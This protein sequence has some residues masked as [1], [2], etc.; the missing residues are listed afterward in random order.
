MPFDAPSFR[1]AM[2]VLATILACLV[3]SPADAQRRIEGQRQG[4]RLYQ[5]PAGQA[6]GNGAVVRP[7]G[8][9]GNDALGQGNV[10]DGSLEV[11]SGGRNYGSRRMNAYSYQNLQARN[12]VVTNNVAGG[13]GFR[14]DVGYRAPGDFSGETGGDSIYRFDRGSALSSLNFLSSDRSLDPFNIAQG[15]GVFQ[16]RRDFTTLPEV[17][18]VAGVR[19]IDDAQI[20][21]D[22]AN[23]VISSSNLIETAVAPS[24]VG[25]V[26][27]AE[28]ERLQASGSTVR[29]IQYRPLNTPG[30]FDLYDEAS[31]NGLAIESDDETPSSGPVRF[32]AA[33]ATRLAE[34]ARIDGSLDRSEAYDRILQR[35]FESYEDRDDV[36]V[37]ATGL[38]RM[39]QDF[40]RIDGLQAPVR[41]GDPDEERPGNSSERRE[42]LPGERIEQSPL[43]DLVDDTMDFEVGSPVDPA[44]AES[45][46]SGESG[47]GSE[48][49]LEEEVPGRRT[50]EEL[51]D[52]LTHRTELET[53][54]DP[55][56]RERV[57]EVAGQAEEAMKGG[58]YF[59]AEER[60][61]LALRLNPGNPILEA[62]LA[63]AQ[64]GAG[65][66]RSAAVTLTSLFRKH[67]EMIDVGWSES[68][69]P[70]AT[71]LILA[72]DDVEKI[73]ERD[74]NGS[75][76]LGI[77]VAY[78]GRQLGDRALIARGLDVIDDP[79][80]VSLVPKLRGIWLAEAGYGGSDAP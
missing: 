43:G 26:A 6:L 15:V 31:W 46:D 44:D 4:G 71:R 1:P 60:F 68:T 29:G 38:Q 70:T 79:R 21:L 69:R 2:P 30:S 36:A 78:I 80:V 61:S 18:T 66:Y 17:N 57:A 23:G 53:F 10:L 32:D 67:P 11:G 48:D 74:P 45:D 73:I 9:L 40:G 77:V 25:V 33:P 5:N 22:R 34:E 19:R 28:A 42:G 50:V 58:D 54:V 76:G 3:A 52:S 16:Y 64:I 62:G 13:R 56:M 75:T 51:L 8:V 24:D 39:R 7:D 20:R 14:G 65:L 47:D 41:I 72:A 63:N 37:D 12:L 35:V 55:K 59:R 27:G 49:D